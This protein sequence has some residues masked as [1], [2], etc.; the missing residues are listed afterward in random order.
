M[1]SQGMGSCESR[2]VEEDRE[3]QRL[4]VSGNDK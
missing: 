1:G 4:K 3:S 2:E